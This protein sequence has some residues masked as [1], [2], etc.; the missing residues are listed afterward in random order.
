MNYIAME[1]PDASLLQY[2]A[3]SDLFSIECVKEDIISLQPAYK[4]PRTHNHGFCVQVQ[5]R[6]VFGNPSCAGGLYWPG[7]LRCTDWQFMLDSEAENDCFGS[8]IS[9]I[10]GREYRSQLLGE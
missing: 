9:A 3:A 8:K 7:I 1:V 4:V 2:L 10:S 5:C 6:F